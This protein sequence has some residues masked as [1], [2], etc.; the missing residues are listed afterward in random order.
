M[1]KK[2]NIIGA[3]YSGLAA[4]C[5]LAKDG[6]DVTI[7][8]K[9]ESIG[10]RSRQF[11]QDGFVFDMGPS[12]YWMPDV[13]DTFFADFGKK[14]SDYYHLHRLSPSYRVVFGENDLVDLPSSLDELYE[15]FERIEKG[16]AAK[17]KIFL[18]EASYKYDVGINEFVQKPSK[19]IMEFASLKVLKG[20]LRL[21]L[22]KSFS[23]YVRQ[24][25]KNPKL[26]QILEFPVLFLGA[27]P[28]NIPALY[29]L[30][31]YA[32]IVGG[33]WYPMGGMF[34]VIEAMNALALELGVKIKTN[35][36]VE[37]IVIEN[38]ITKGLK[39][40]GN[41]YPSDSVLASADY[42]FVEQNLIPKE[43]RKYDEAYWDKR[44]MAPSSLLFYLGI[45]KKLKNLLHHNLF[46]DRDFDQHA[47]EIYDTPEWPSDPLFYACVPSI[48]DAAVAPEGKE[49][50]FLLMPIAPGLNDD[51]TLREKYYHVIMD[52]L[53][54]LTDQEIRSH[55]IYKKSYAVNDFIADYNA[56][57]GNAY[58]LA[59]TLKQTAVLKPAMHNSK[60]K[61]LFFAGQLTVPGPGVPP[62][63]ISGKIAAIESIKHFKTTT[64]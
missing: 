38:G 44:V 27:K 3:G 49:N 8:E 25:F 13:F 63:L 28:Q 32:D 31:N 52:R 37:E 22:F 61:N 30:M 34:K 35:H 43:Y 62:S 9:N 54:K 36:A 47:V 15:T 57:K 16:S 40:K 29:S 45:D 42:H 17:L 55:V 18:D 48:T 24:Y 64:K 10:G 11:E 50:L 53:E 39:S 4:A 14:T 1:Q 6:V 60:I 41:F 56:F 33:T 26:I 5:Y 19:S 46:F 23:K 7:F 59:N 12:W 51:E 20:A 58:G 21:Q 2:V